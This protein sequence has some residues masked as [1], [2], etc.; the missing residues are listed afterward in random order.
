MP[1]NDH[2]KKRDDIHDTA[3]ER[4]GKT[5]DEKNMKEGG[6][7]GGLDEN[8]KHGLGEAEDKIRDRLKR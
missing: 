6:T 4:S 5:K 8:T 2:M 3:K 1:N 7:S